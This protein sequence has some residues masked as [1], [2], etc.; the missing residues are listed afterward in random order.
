MLQLLPHLQRSVNPQDQA[1][2]LDTWNE[3]NEAPVAIWQL[4][5][6]P[7]CATT[8]K[9]NNLPQD[10]GL[11]MAQET[12]SIS[13]MHFF[14]HHRITECFGLEGIFRI[15][16]FHPLPWKEGMIPCQSAK[17]LKDRSSFFFLGKHKGIPS[18]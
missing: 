11:G 16:V 4:V 3:W 18:G 17:L 2:C 6:V 12:L 8:Q 14:S 7:G 9:E 1:L 15:I 5:H 13:D 10:E